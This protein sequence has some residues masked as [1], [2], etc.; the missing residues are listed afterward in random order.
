M[1]NNSNSSDLSGPLAIIGLIAIAAGLL[2]ML[3]LPAIKL[4]AWLLLAVGFVAL[5]AAFFIGFKRVKQSI[6]SRHGQF[7]LGTGVMALIFIGIFL[8]V[9]AISINNYQRFD[10]SRL[11]QFTLTSSTVNLLTNLKT[12]V[13]VTAFFIPNDTSGI[14]SN[15]ANLLAEYQ[16]HTK[17]LTVQYIDPDAHP[18]LAKRY[19]ITMYQTVVFESGNQ[20]KL[21]LPTQFLMTDQQGNP[22]GIEAEHSFSSAILEV[23]GVAQKKVYF[24]TGHGEDDINSNFSKAKEGLL[25]E[26]YRVDT[27]NLLT[28][29]AIP[30]DCAALIIAAPRTT[31]S[32][33]E[34]T[35]VANHLNNGG[36]VLILTDPDSASGIE[37]VVASWGV[38]IGNGNVIDLASFV[39]PNS[40]TPLI[41]T[42]KNYFMLPNVYFP[43]AT[44][45]IP[46]TKIPD[47]IQM[48]PMA[49]T[50]NTSW[51][52]KDFTPGKEPVFNAETEKRESLAIGVMIAGT[53][54]VATTGKYTRLI[55][56]GDSDFASNTHYS[57]ANNSDLFVDSVN[58]L[59]EETSLVSIHRNVQPFSRLVVTQEQAIFIEWS[60]ILLLP[61]LLIVAAAV[62]W[63]R[64]K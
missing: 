41:P 12:P 57:S 4:S 37:K 16:A 2:V 64:R 23:T 45:I 5:V 44:A 58:W 26:L 43:G 24:L 49:Y 42:N 50:G 54:P 55:V 32:D 25:N 14:S 17:Q 30:K 10:T 7:R 36:Q 29:P 18:D 40:D 48:I 35:I 6:I 3:L 59:A 21:V 13:K 9:N 39:S 27:L 61:S 19:G 60:S 22:T 31:I 51:L 11:S 1:T 33:S 56:I 53:Q 28:T 47:K 62:S 20:S 46:Q 8:F 63:W 15:V 52:D 34:V 38:E